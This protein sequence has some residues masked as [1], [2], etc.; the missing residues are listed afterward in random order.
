[1]IYD[2]IVIGAGPA[3]LSSAIYLGRAR[4]KT[5]LIHSAP[6]RT[7]LA[8]HINNYLGMDDVSG[9]ELI[10]LGLKQAQRYGVEVLL[11]TVRNI[12]KQDVF[13][14][15]TAEGIYSARYVIVASGINDVLPE[16]DNLYDFMG[17]TFF[18]CFDCDGYR[19]TD[20]NVIILGRGDGSA[21]T[22]LAI[23]Q[24]YTDRITILAGK[25]SKISNEYLARMNQEKIKVINKSAVHLN[26]DSGIVNSAVLDDGSV[27]ECDCVLSEL[28][29][30][31]NDSFL[32]GLDVKRSKPGYI[33][34]DSH[35]ETS[36]PGLFAIG[37]V[38]TGSDQVPV[39]VGEGAAAAM[40]IIESE[41]KLEA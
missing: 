8:V 4:K 27:I 6:M 7:S 16:I 17:E 23:K 10:E 5:L 31:R 37:P 34:V 24:T 29:Y 35:Y 22:A 41:F 12:E 9:P 15:W 36:I 32:L 13:K 18:T 28:G 26:G 38:N 11:A 14:V 39:A 19:M 21:R 25:D 20:K 3:G 2:C 33:E 30:E 1:M 40:H